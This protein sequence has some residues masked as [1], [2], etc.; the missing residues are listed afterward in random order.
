MDI[1]QTILLASPPKVQPGKTIWQYLQVLINADDI[2]EDLT[3]NRPPLNI[4]LVLDRSGSM[5]GSSIDYTRQS[6]IKFVENLSSRDFISVVVYDDIIEPIIPAMPMPK[7]R[8]VIIDS[9]N[10]IETRGSTNLYGG[11]KEGI[12]Q[13]RTFYK[14]D[15]TNR[16]ILFSDGIANVGRTDHGEITQKIKQ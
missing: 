9:I 3:K 13:V 11:V 7:D 4:A 8:S 10:Q 6:A 12:K 15:I 14:D 5:Q 2:P 1:V 16:V